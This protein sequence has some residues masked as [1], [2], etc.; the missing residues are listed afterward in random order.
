MFQG[1]DQKSSY[2]SCP[3]IG[4]TQFPIYQGSMGNT[5]HGGS[6]SMSFA[7]Q[8]SLQIFQALNLAFVY[9]HNEKD[10]KVMKLWNIYD[11]SVLYSSKIARCGSMIYFHTCFLFSPLMHHHHQMSFPRGF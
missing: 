1:G 9:I 11:T 3:Q 7:S 8:L 5:V 4:K 6:N 10:I 2:P